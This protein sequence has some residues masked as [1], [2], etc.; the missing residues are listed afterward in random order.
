MALNNNGKYFE[1]LREKYD[2]IILSAFGLQAKFQASWRIYSLAR[3]F[4]E[5][6]FKVTLI[7]PD[8]K[9]KDK[10]SIEDYINVIKVPQGIIQT[11]FK[12]AFS[13]FLGLRSLFKK[14]KPLKTAYLVD[15]KTAQIYNYFFLS[16]K[17]LPLIK[18]FLK[19][20]KLIKRACLK[21]KKVILVTSSGPGSY[22]L[23][24]FLLKK[25]FKDKIVWVADYRDPLSNNQI[26]LSRPLKILE[27]T[28]RL[29]LKNANFITT[30]ENGTL[31][32]LK[33]LKNN[34]KI[35]QNPIFFEIQPGIEE[36]N[37]SFESSTEKSILTIYYG[38]TIYYQQLHALKAFLM[39]LKKRKDLRFVYSGFSA[40]LLKNLAQKIS[41]P[42]NRLQVL[43]VLDKKEY[44][45][46]IAESNILLVI[47][48]SDPKYPALGGKLYKLLQFNK[49]L[50]VISAQNPEILELAR[51]AGG[52]YLAEIDPEKVEQAI[53]KIRADLSKKNVFRKAEFFKEFSHKNQVR[54]FLE[55]LADLEKNNL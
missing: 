51:L 44:E 2:V 4:F 16:K 7:T 3:G 36:K 47:G 33:D 42:Q 45:K 49:P 25:V 20:R 35:K 23:L 19:A 11:F 54:K 43:D 24:G 38:G 39:V 18:T 22:H 37:L 6:G 26:L 15:S 10:T 29:T 13:S 31:Q 55:K 28:D 9:E 32:A 1:V 48:T 12:L 50:L 27:V 52:V 30:P 53:E 40:E 5:N 17:P 21:E 34:L 41:I 14:S 46:K 8:S